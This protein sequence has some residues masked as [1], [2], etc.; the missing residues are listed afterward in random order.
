M[1]AAEEKREVTEKT[2]NCGLNQ[3]AVDMKEDLSFFFIEEGNCM[4]QINI[5]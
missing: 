2:E 5:R 1:S 4:Y 3:L